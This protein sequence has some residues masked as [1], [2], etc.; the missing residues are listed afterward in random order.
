[1]KK[2]VKMLCGLKHY[3]FYYFRLVYI[4]ITTFNKVSS[5]AVKKCVSKSSNK[6]CAAQF[7][8]DLLEVPVDAET[9]KHK[10]K[11]LSIVCSSVK[12]KLLRCKLYSLW[13]PSANVFVI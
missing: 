3:S 9:Q 2:K 1:M 13:T 7:R 8:R 11:T 4:H 12:V 6:K 10:P 5:V